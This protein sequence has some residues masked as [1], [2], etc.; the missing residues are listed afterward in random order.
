MARI[1]KKQEMENKLEKVR[2]LQVAFA[3]YADEE[4]NDDIADTLAICAQWLK[5]ALADDV[6]VE[7]LWARISDGLF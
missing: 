2:V 4:Y 3:A 7:G 5:Q 1:S 6:T